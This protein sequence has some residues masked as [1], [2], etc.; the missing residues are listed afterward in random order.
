M[1]DKYRI[2]SDGQRTN[3]YAPDGTEIRN[4]TSIEIKQEAG[5]SVIANV[6]FVLIRPDLDIQCGVSNG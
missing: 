3:I 6:T 2:V 1:A 5:R 4:V